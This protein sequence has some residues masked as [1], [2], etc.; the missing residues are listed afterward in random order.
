MK[1]MTEAEAIEYI[2]NN[3]ENLDHSRNE[4]FAVRGDDYIPARKFRNSWDRP[5][6]VKTTRLDGVCACFVA[7]NDM[8]GD[9][10]DVS[11]LPD[12]SAY[13]RHRFLLR[14]EK[15]GYGND[16]W[17]SEI[18]LANHKIIAIIE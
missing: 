10:L 11:S 17:S 15:L 6:G 9:Y 12:T 7:E 14:G 1:R 5:D 13:G 4:C 2:R 3:A 8:F 16:E 18:I